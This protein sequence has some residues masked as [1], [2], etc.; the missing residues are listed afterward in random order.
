MT[1]RYR[2]RTRVLA[3]HAAGATPAM[4]DELAARMPRMDV[5]APDLVG[6]AQVTGGRPGALVR[7][8][9][10]MVP[11]GPILL[12]G[13]EI[14]ANL[15]LEVAALLGARAAGVLLLSPCPLRPTPTYRKRMR[16]LGTLMEMQLTED[17]AAAWTPLV[18]NRAAPGAA[19]AAEKAERMLREV[20]QAI[21]P[22]QHLAADFPDGDAALG[23]IR[24]PI[25]AFFGAESV[26][27]FPG[28]TLIPEWKRALGEDRVTLLE[29]AREWL[30]LEKPKEVADALA[31]LPLVGAVEE[32]LGA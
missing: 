19:H 4:W 5:L 32:S 13:C 11:L 25:R 6:L 28:P 12:T 10:A 26:N 7:A 3:L 20:G 22:L 18:V 27:P 8:L 9:L 2:Q 14:G 29:H 15:A 24:A 23:N 31:A 30:P 1:K 17:E 16:H 21:A